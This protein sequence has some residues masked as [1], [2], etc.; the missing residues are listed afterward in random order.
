MPTAVGLVDV[1]AL[2]QVR[3][4]GVADVLR[5]HPSEQVVQQPLAQRAVRDG[6]LLYAERLEGG[7]DNG[8]APRKHRRTLLIDREQIETVRPTGRQ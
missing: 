5:M 7:R 1:V 4:R 2:D 8:H 3:H 6:H